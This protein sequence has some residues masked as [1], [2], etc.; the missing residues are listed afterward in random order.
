MTILIAANTKPKPDRYTQNIPPGIYDGTAP[1]IAFAF[2]KWNRPKIKNGTA[3]N[4]LATIVVNVFIIWSPYFYFK[5][6]IVFKIKSRQ[7]MLN[8]LKV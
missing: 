2:I 8:L 5:V 3:N 6:M 4:I 1:A 7:L